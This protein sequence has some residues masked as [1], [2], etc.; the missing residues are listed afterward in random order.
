MFL[1]G[2]IPKP[3]HMNLRMSCEFT[4]PVLTENIFNV[5]S[6]SMWKV[7]S[8][9]S[10]KPRSNYKWQCEWETKKS[11]VLKN[12]YIYSTGNV[13]KSSVL[14]KEWECSEAYKCGMNSIT[15]SEKGKTWLSSFSLCSVFN[16]QLIL[17]LFLQL[18][19]Q[20]ISLKNH[21]A[22]FLTFTCARHCS[23]CRRWLLSYSLPV[24]H[25]L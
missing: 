6:V 17:N 8:Y 15:W 3:W 13:K 18:R 22:L 16:T 24:V 7:T 10:Y 12:L 4:T 25:S 20:G 11:N 23:L 21:S 5:W 19:A 1:L 9:L 14:N 2:Y